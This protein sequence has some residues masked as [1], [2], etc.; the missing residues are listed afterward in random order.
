MLHIIVF[1]PSNTTREYARAMAKETGQEKKSYNLAAQKFTPFSLDD[2][3]DDVLLLVPVY[4]GRVP[5]LAA[6]RIKSIEGCGQRAFIAV[7]YGNRDY[8][9]A[10]LELADLATDAGLEVVAA[11]AFIGQHSIF[12]KVAAGRP[13]ASDRQ[14]ASRFIKEALN[15]HSHLDLNRIKGTRPYKKYGAIPFRPETDRGVCASCGT[16]VRECPTGAISAGT[17]RTDSTKCI[18][19]GRCITMCP[20]KSRGYRSLLHKSVGLIFGAQ[21]KRRL[22]PEWW[23]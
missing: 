14:A 7:V 15:H 19:C 11:G 21:N 8:D 10:L 5:A 16:C 13:D 3:D 2:P 22:E 9:D 1:S 18:A 17:L 6:E 4:G 12:P 23:I 20:R